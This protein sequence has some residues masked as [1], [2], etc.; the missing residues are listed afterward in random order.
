[1]FS[2]TVH[3]IILA[4][5]QSTRMGEPKQT[6]SIEGHTLIDH[7]VLQASKLPVERIVVIT[8][9]H[10]EVI[11]EAVTIEDSRLH[12]IH[13]PDYAS[14]QASS[15]KKGLCYAQSRG[16]HALVM[17]ADQPLIADET[18]KAVLDEGLSMKASRK[19]YSVRPMYHGRQGHPVFFG[20]PYLLNLMCLKMPGDE[21]G[22][23]LR[24]QLLNLHTA[25]DDPFISFDVDTP[26]ELKK[27]RELMKKPIPVL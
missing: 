8:G 10:H 24:N 25:V 21:G 12:F 11:K 13:N 5:G 7:A 9:E 2:T 26:A 1:M 14:G 22:K 20:R 16:A 18:F 23:R 15:L 3:A 27:A 19:P 4:A 6:L 17:L